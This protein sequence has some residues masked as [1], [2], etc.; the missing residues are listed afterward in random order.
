M[1]QTKSTGNQNQQSAREHES[2]D[3]R[4]KRE[5]G[6]NTDKSSHDA[7]SNTKAGQQTGAGGGAKQERHH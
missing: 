6:V 5:A 4:M 3:E 2:E 7:K 1:T